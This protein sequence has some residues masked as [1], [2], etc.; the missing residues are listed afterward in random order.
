MLC[1]RTIKSLNP[2]HGLRARFI[3][4]R[5]HPEDGRPSEEQEGERQA[6]QDH[7]RQIH[8]QE[9]R[10]EGAR[11]QEDAGEIGEDDGPE[12]DQ[13]GQQQIVRPEN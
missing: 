4:R 10:R 5:V 12:A 3:S 2:L 11:R 13:Q 7:E 8:A 9:E 1:D 6:S